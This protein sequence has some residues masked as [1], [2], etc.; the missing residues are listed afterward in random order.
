MTHAE[1]R[2]LRRELINE[3][4]HHKWTNNLWIRSWVRAWEQYRYGKELQAYK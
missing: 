4:I 3:A 2:F 1:M